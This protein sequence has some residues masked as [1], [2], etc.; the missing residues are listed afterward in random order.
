VIIKLAVRN[1]TQAV[2]VAMHE[3]LF[4]ISRLNRDA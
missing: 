4:K 3:I 2:S 1:M